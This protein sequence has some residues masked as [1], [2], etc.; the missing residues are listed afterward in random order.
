MSFSFFLTASANESPVSVRTSSA[1]PT[2]ADMA[3]RARASAERAMAALMRQGRELP[4][5]ARGCRATR[6]GKQPGPEV[7]RAALRPVER[8]SGLQASVV[9]S[10][11]R[12]SRVACT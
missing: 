1:R 4:A 10:V 9:H 11:E 3:T 7:D 5:R 6:C 12:G 8:K 2:A